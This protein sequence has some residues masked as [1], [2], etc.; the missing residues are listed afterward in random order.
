[1]N[2]NRWE[3]ERQGGR[4]TEGKIGIKKNKKNYER[5]HEISLYG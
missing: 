2:G 5:E 1:M 3:F 4:K